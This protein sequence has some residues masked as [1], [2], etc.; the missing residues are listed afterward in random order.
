MEVVNPD[1]AA[2]GSENR[3][4][5]A[6]G[7]EVRASSAPFGPESTGAAAGI[8]PEFSRPSFAALAGL[9]GLF[10]FL[11]GIG[12][13]S[14]GLIAQPVRSLLIR[15]GKSTA[16]IGALSAY[17][18]LPWSIK[19]IYGLI[20]DFVPLAGYH[21][22]SYLVLTSA[23]AAA[24][25]L[26]LSVMRLGPDDTHTLLWLLLLPTFGVAFGDVVIDALMIQRGQPYGWTGELQAVQ[27]SAMFAAMALTGVLGGY[28]SQH[29]LEHV[30]FAICGGA[31][32]VA[33][34]VSLLVREE[35]ATTKRGGRAVHAGMLRA[36][37]R[38]PALQAAAVFLLLWNFNPFSTSVL[39][40]YMTRELGFSQQ[41]YG[42]TMTITAVASMAGAV[43]YG[44]VRTRVSFRLL[45]HFAIA[46]GIASTAAYWGL[47]REFSAQVVSAA[48]GFT[49]AVALLIQ[50]DLAAQVCPAPIAGTVFAA[51][52]SL[53]NLSVSLSGSI[54]G[55]AYDWLREDIGERAA[56]DRLVLIGSLTTAGCWLVMP[57]LSRGLAKCPPPADSPASTTDKPADGAISG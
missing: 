23:L 51:L 33:A 11:Q 37:C 14:D 18:L 53:V 20:S 43:L 56:F 31:C 7:A 19:P 12:E 15:W 55:Y 28:L 24:A 46:L 3:G 22:K 48:T 34:V 32:L 49:S 25:L 52:M 36:A 4:A 42:N 17:L 45:L 38:L 30:G 5:E 47:E 41:F 9:F 2:G 40:V 6:H 1:G 57:W 26:A 16:E 10:Y 35:R 54:G 44:L 29:E 27:W 13:P 21:R 50:L 39:H 8:Q